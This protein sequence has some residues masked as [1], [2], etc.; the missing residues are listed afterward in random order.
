MLKFPKIIIS[1]LSGIF[2]IEVLSSKTKSHK[3]YPVVYKCCKQKA[4]YTWISLLQDHQLQDLDDFC[5]GYH[6]SH[7]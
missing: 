7:I 3:K 6:S 1:D 5:K 4:S 2:T